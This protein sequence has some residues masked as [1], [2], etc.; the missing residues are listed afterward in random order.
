MVPVTEFVIAREDGASSY[1]E[2]AGY[3]VDGEVVDGFLLPPA[4][5]NGVQSLAERD[6]Y[7][8]FASTCRG[9]AARIP[10]AGLTDDRAPDA[11]AADIEVVSAR[12]GESET[13][14]GLA[15]NRFDASDDHLYA[16]D[17][18]R[19]QSRAMTNMTVSSE[20]APTVASKLEGQQAFAPCGLALASRRHGT[21]LDLPRRRR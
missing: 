9:G 5:S 16:S 6:G 4:P 1:L 8:Y 12:V 20:D 10:L 17:S 3:P 21:V 19:L 11:R 14:H 13:L 15:F 7:L 18:F 2:H